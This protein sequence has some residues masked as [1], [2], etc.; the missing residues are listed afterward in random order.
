[1]EAEQ[2]L[3]AVSKLVCILARQTLN[4]LK[5]NPEI[6]FVG[7]FI[8]AYECARRAYG[9]APGPGRDDGP[10]GLSIS[11]PSSGLLIFKT[12]EEWAFSSHL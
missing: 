9:I 12:V 4:G 10:M 7:P 3:G 6:V 2:T 11:E 8:I 5:W 1:M